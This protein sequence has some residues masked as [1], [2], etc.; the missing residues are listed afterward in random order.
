MSSG[1]GS[2]SRNT[3][4]AEAAGHD[5]NSNRLHDMAQGISKHFPQVP[6]MSCSALK[7]LLDDPRRA[8]DVTV[9]DVRLPEEVEVSRIP[10]SLTTAQ[11]EAQKAELLAAGKKEV[12]AYCTI[13]YRSSAYAAKLREQG[14]DAK[15]LEGSIVRWAQKRYPLVAGGGS[16]DSAEQETKRVHVYGKQWALQPEDY[17]AVMF[18]HPF[19]SSAIKGLRQK[20]PGWLG[21]SG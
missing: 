15:N 6:L 21:G 7:G 11:F 19:L 8:A 13:G 9:V 16:G 14:F 4:L 12:V 1:K 5:E 18:K 17:E 20:L 2:L 3:T 10:G